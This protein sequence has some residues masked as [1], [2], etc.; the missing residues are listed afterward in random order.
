MGSEFDVIKRYFDRPVHRKDV[1]KGIGDD[2]AVLALPANSELVVSTDT[3]VCGTH[4]LPDIAPA[5]LAHKAVA[6]NLSDLAAMGAEPAWMTLAITLPGEDSDWLQ[7]FS[8]G[9][10]EICQ[11]YGV[12]LIGGDTTRGPLSL[13]VTIHGHLPE[14][15]ALLR[16]GARIGDW[17]YVTGNLGD[18]AA[19]LQCLLGQLA[20]AP[21][22]TEYLVE[23][24]LRPRPRL[25]AGRALRGRASSAMDLSD[26]LASDL[27]HIL[28]ASGAGAQLELEQLPMSAVLK[29][30]VSAERALELALAGGEDYELLFTVP[31]AEKGALATAL[32]ETG[33]NHTCIGQIVAGEGIRYLKEGAPVELTLSGYDHFKEQE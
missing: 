5:D 15:R 24:H 11:Y 23:K 26:G 6:V 8:E 32:A 9:L 28:A 13:T 19:G 14:G 20:L 4:F 30:A 12:A 2:G 25:L 29:G 10:H 22:A 18:S 33:I 3:L 27:G 31:E 16:D 7:A 17:I 21:E 1:L